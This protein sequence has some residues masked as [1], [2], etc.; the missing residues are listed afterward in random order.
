MDKEPLAPRQPAAHEDVGPDGKGGFTQ[1]RRLGHAQPLG[2]RQRVIL[3]GDRVFGIAPA[4][5]QSADP[6]PTFQRL[7]PGPTAG[8]GARALAAPA[9]SDASAAGHLGCPRVA[10]R[11]RG[12]RPHGPPLYQDLFRTRTVHGPSCMVTSALSRLRRSCLISIAAAYSL[13]VS[14]GALRS[15]LVHVL[16]FLYIFFFFFFCWRSPLLSDWQV[17]YFF[18][19]FFHLFL[20]RLLY[21]LGLLISSILFIVFYRSAPAESR[22]GEALPRSPDPALPTREPGHLSGLSSQPVFRAWAFFAASILAVTCPD[23]PVQ[24]AMCRGLIPSTLGRPARYMHGRG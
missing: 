5:Q 13:S 21:G 20:C 15:P 17:G 12:S 14:W 19:F 18:F 8:D 6:S 1:R 3:M 10:A 22:T 9:V 7:T 4:R 23:A 11:R 24:K 2:H 16:G